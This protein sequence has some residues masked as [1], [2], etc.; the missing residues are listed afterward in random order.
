MSLAIELSVVEKQ[1]GNLT[2]LG[3]HSWWIYITDSKPLELTQDQDDRACYELSNSSERAEMQ[4][5]FPNWN[6]RRL[7]LEMSFCNCLALRVFRGGPKYV[8]RR[9]RAFGVQLTAL[10]GVRP[11][12]TLVEWQ[13]SRQR[14]WN[15][16]PI[17]PSRGSTRK[18]WI[19]IWWSICIFR[20]HP[21][22]S[23]LLK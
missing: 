18:Q 23:L 2:D 16:G 22:H 21:I 20:S 17:V 11:M 3:K 5:S 19:R 6:L 15:P 12:Q 9:Y 10:E 4:R 14:V 7:L 1:K 8:R 13:S